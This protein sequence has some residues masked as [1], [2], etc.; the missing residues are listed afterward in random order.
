MFAARWAHRRGMRHMPD[1]FVR[2]PFRVSDAAGHL[3]AHDLSGPLWHSPHHG[4]R[5]CALATDTS[6]MHRVLAAAALVRA[7]AALGGWCAAYLLGAT[8]LDG[9]DACGTAAPVVLALPPHSQVR[10]PGVSCIRSPLHDDDIVVIGGIPVTSPVRTAFDLARTLPLTEAVVALDAMARAAGVNLDDV[11]AYVE[12][13][14]RWKG[15]PK[16]KRA[17]ALADPRARSCQETRFRLL[18]VLEAG[19][20]TPLVNW[21]VVDKSGQLLGEIDLLDPTAGLAGEYDGATH[22]Q[23]GAHARD[24]AR[25]EWLEAAG[26]V[27]VRAT[28]ID[29][30]AHRGRLIHRLRVAHGR[31][32]QRDKRQDA[33]HVVASPD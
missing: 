12:D 1:R 14:P 33:W 31:A 9:W 17:L 2:R 24:N 21:S 4:V 22:R 30:T 13:R 32:L 20:P 18:W 25:E 3:T 29:L 7:G 15:V 16:T 11:V 28:S 23:L 10:R 27:V 6:P 5:S 19:L 26:L 8:E